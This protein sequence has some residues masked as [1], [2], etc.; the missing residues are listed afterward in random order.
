VSD[1]FEKTVMTRGEIISEDARRLAD[2]R[3]PIIEWLTLLHPLMERIVSRA[4]PA[5][6]RFKRV[7]SDPA[8]ESPWEPGLK[9]AGEES[10]GMP[11]PNGARESLRGIVGEGVET[12][13]VHDDSQADD[14]A[15]SH[16]AK[17]VTIGSDIFFRKG[18]LRPQEPQGF[19][20]L[21]HEAT[22]VAQALRPGAAWRRATA[23]GVQEEEIEAMGRERAM[24]NAPLNFR[25]VL[26]GPSGRTRKNGGPSVKF[27]P[28]SPVVRPMKSDA[29]AAAPAVTPKETPAAAGLDDMRRTLFRDLLSHIRTEFERGA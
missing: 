3:M 26:H 20:L 27:A 17:A 21:A 18:L 4:S 11:L 25:P 29:D 16:H 28:Q 23:G 22:H 7:E 19:A 9:T 5:Q 2:M 10:E 6:T 15:R 14:I 13:R 1:K 8:A 12:I 24:L